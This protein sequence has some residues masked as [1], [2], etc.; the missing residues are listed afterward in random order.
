[1][2]SETREVSPEGSGQSGVRPGIVV[3][4][5][6]AT[7]HHGFVAVVGEGNYQ[8][9]LRALASRLG[10]EG[11]FTARLVPEPHNSHDVNAVSVCVDEMAPPSVT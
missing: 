4:T 1:M 9:A 2:S 7:G 8:S 6:F 10:P 5:T 3:T 11:V